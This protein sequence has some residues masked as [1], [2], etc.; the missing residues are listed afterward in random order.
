[1]SN[2]KGKVK[3]S[4]VLLVDDH[5]V[6]RDGLMRLINEQPDLEVCC[7]ADDVQSALEQ[8]ELHKPDVAV[9]DISLKGRSGLDILRSLK[10]SSALPVLILSMH[11][12]ML[13]AERALKAGAKGYVMKEEAREKLLL[14]LRSILKGG[15][16]VSDKL[17]VRVLKQ[18]FGGPAPKKPTKPGAT[19]PIGQLSDRELEV[20]RLLGQG[21]G[22]RQIADQLNLSVKTIETYRA[23]IMEKLDLKDARELIRFAVQSVQSGNL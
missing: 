15:I 1:M 17:A 6:V 8:I 16:Y 2:P 5:P 22:T 21:N 12:E 4:R 11:D 20:F 10:G 9:V 14:G 7:E 3:K 23:H 13:Y 19:S 18:H